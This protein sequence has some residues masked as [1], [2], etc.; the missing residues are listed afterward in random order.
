MGKLNNLYQLNLTKC[1]LISLKFLPLV[2]LTI[3]LLRDNM[4]SDGEVEKITI[5]KNL[6][7]VDLRGNK[8]KN[9]EALRCFNKLE[10]I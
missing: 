4:I 3:L 5:Y 8:I 9:V 6:Q 7:Q 1:G 10:K 2:D